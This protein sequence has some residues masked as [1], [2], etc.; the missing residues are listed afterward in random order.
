MLDPNI[1]LQGQ[2]PD[3]MGAIDQGRN[4]AQA[5]IG[6][7]QQNALSRLYQEQGAGIAN[8][9]QGALNALAG[10]DPAAAQSAQ[11]GRLGIQGQQQDLAF[12]AEKMQMARDEAKAHTAQQ[13]AA[14]QTAM[15]A[16]EAADHA[17][18]VESGVAAAMAAKTPEQWDAVAQQFGVPDLVGQFAN[19]ESVAASY[20]GVADALKEFT[21]KPAAP[22]DEYQRYVQEEGAANRTP[23]GRI[24]FENAKKGKGVSM[25][26][27]NPDG[28]TTSMSFGGAAG[29]G[30]PTVGQVY[31]PNEISSVL[32]MIDE[33]SANPNL[34]KV[35]GSIEGGGGNN[36]DDLNIAQRAYYGGD[37]TALI[38]RI[39]Q[40]QNNA[41]LSARAMLKNGGAITDYESRKAEGAVA[42]LSRAK[43]EDQ[44]RTALKDLRDA[45]TAGEAKLKGQG[46]DN[47]SP[48]ANPT[49]PTILN[50]NP[51]TGDFE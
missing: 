37:G 27:T 21:A 3:I 7:N 51:E 47:P 34:D 41:W 49:A 12:N 14:Q 30:E 6:M 29:T 20:M 46:G 45:I 10:F 19:R 48:T 28:S 17:A 18:Q 50:F 15:S 40:L 24:E 39:G 36:I 4:S 44:F 11:S 5:Q 38:E 1:I 32:G 33:I 26:T 42:R 43:S 2:T 35:V 8:G 13:L 22:A 25:S 31:N 23:L 9:D 16:Q